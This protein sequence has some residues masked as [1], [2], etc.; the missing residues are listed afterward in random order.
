[1]S[2]QQAVILAAAGM[3]LV[4]AVTRVVR[5]HFG[6]TPH[7]D[8]VGRLLFVLV[9]LFGPPVGLE[10]LVNPAAEM[11]QVHGIESVL[12]YIVAVGAF[13]I[14]MIIAA[15]IVGVA[16]PGRSRRLLL[17]ALLGTEGDPDDVPFDPPVTAKLAEGVAL[18]DQA[19]AAFPRGPG[20][21]SQ[22]DRA[23][24]R[25]AWDGLDAAT[26]ALEGRI[27]DEHRLGVAVASE[28]SATARDARSR[29]DTLRRL[30]VDS[31]QS[32]AN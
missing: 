4:L 27:A 16:A 11:G 29:L 24:F 6:R 9:F 23:D 2:L 31:G 22:V 5:V 3:L 12:L 30:A 1:M 7:P 14:L 18:V 32:W 8:G 20:F 25:I 26:V 17:L 21:A 28:A 10:L 15:G 13:S 19:N